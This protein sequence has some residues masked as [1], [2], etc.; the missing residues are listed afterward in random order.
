MGGQGPLIEV[1]R[2]GGASSFPSPGP[3][4]NIHTGDC[5]VFLPRQLS[6][7]GKNL[8]PPTYQFSFS[9]STF[10]TSPPLFPSPMEANAQV[11]SSKYGHVVPATPERARPS[12]APSGGRDRSVTLDSVKTGGSVARVRFHHGVC[13]SSL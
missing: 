12:T 4:P 13:M 3:A 2:S 6:E 1:W 9:T 10:P 5:E 11:T 8:F 7:I